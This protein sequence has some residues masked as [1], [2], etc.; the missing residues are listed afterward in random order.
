MWERGIHGYDRRRALMPLY[1]ANAMLK[2][3]KINCG[4]WLACESGRVVTDAVTD[5]PPSR[6]SQLPH[7]ERIGL[8]DQVSSTARILRGKSAG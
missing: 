5:T 3:T 6:A 1:Q 8:L 2:A 7:F 4:S